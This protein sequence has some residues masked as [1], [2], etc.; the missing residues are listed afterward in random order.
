MIKNIKVEES[1]HREL[2][3]LGSMGESF[4]NVIKKL[5]RYYKSG[6]KKTEK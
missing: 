5:I 6:G 1:T 4:D 2:R 3:S